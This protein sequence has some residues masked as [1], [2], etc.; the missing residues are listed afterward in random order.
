MD[1]VTSLLNRTLPIPRITT[2][3][4]EVVGGFRARQTHTRTDC[5]SESETHSID[6]S[7][8]KPVSWIE[9]ILPLQIF[10]IG[11]LYIVAVPGEPTTMSGR[12]IRESV[13]NALLANGA[14]SD[15]RVVTAGLSNSYS[16][17]IATYEEYTVQRYEGASTLYGPNTLAAYQYL[18]SGLAAAL[19]TGTPVPPGPTPQD[20]TVWSDF[21]VHLS[22]PSVVCGLIEV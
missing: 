19:Q 4:A 7:I 1:R 14:S 22:T 13:T 16:H 5:M 2:P 3:C 20:L 10:R 11:Q 12:R 18:Y 21:T 8:Y 6:G 17:Y 9:T 15:I